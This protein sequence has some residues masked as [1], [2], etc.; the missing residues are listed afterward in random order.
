VGA[1][2][3]EKEEEREE[4]PAIVEDVHHHETA[5]FIS[6][7][8]AVQRFSLSVATDGSRMKTPLIALKNLGVEVKHVFPCDENI[9]ANGTI[10]ANYPPK[11]FFD[12]HTK[13]DNAKAATADLYVAGFLYQPFATAAGLQQGFYDARGRYLSFWHVR[14]YLEQQRPRMF[15]LG[16]ISSLV[17]MNGG[18]YYRATLESLGA[19][20]TYNVH[21]KFMD[22]AEHGGPHSRQR[23]YFIGISKRHDDGSFCFPDPVTRPSIEMFLDPPVRRQVQGSVPPTHS[24][25]ARMNVCR[26]LKELSAVNVLERL[27][28]RALPAAG[29]VPHGTLTDRWA[30][31]NTPTTLM[32]AGSRKPTAKFFPAKLGVVEE[33]HEEEE[34]KEEEEELAVIEEIHHDEVAAFISE[35]DSAAAIVQELWAGKVQ[36]RGGTAGVIPSRED[37]VAAYRH[38]GDSTL[39]GPSSSLAMA[40]ART[41]PA[42]VDARRCLLPGTKVLTRCYGEINAADL[43]T[44]AQLHG[45]STPTVHVRRFLPQRS[46]DVIAVSFMCKEG[47][48]VPENGIKLTASH[49]L[50]V[51]RPSCPTFKPTLASEI[52]VGDFLRTPSAEVCV[53]Q[54]GRSVEQ[55]EVIEIELEDVQS[56]MYIARDGSPVEAYGALTP[57]LRNHEDASIL[58]F[59]RF[60]NFWEALMVNEELAACRSA[61]TRAGFNADLGLYGL[62]PSKMLVR[63]DM[64]ESVLQ[65]LHLRS[66]RLKCSDVVVSREFK[67]IVEFAVSQSSRRNIFVQRQEAL[68]LQRANV[69]R[70]FVEVP[71]S[72]SSESAVTRSTTDAHLGFGRNPRKRAR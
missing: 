47:A 38:D 56:T 30:C 60:D 13:R 17:L 18:E 44:G 50:A 70:T 11:G 29:L 5:A 28:V 41:A 53:Q 52:R 58:T 25:T 51:R 43:G 42:A 26:T 12:D 3:E 57:P 39:R 19:L 7:P 62:G 6:E 37:G 14:G 36:T 34:E 15:V 64:A 9:G 1:E 2:E 8:A 63:A 46:R 23:I 72:S 22:T 48:D 32:A 35:P 69:K 49:V 66:R 20:K 61:L 54:V 67:P 55:T 16:S 31:G 24:T 71:S 21:S 65:A 10:M 27:F 33:E 59:N 45:Q 40:S 68:N 4:A